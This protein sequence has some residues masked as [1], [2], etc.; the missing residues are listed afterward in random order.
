MSFYHWQDDDLLLDCHLQPG[1]KRAEFAGQH[2]E[3]LKIRISAPPVDGKANDALIRFLADAFAVSR[4]Q[5]SLLS[6]QS[7]RQKRLRIQTPRQLPAELGIQ[8]R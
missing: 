7:S 4:Q 6:G 1:A 5:V 3:R 8:R 2:G